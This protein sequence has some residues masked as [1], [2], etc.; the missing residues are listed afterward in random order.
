MSVKKNKPLKIIFLSGFNPDKPPSH[1][2]PDNDYFYVSSWAGLI[3]RRYK[4]RFP[5]SDVEIWRAEPDFKGETVRDV[6]GL[7]G[8][9]FP[10]RRPL[11]K[12]VL[13][14]SMYLR[15]RRLQKNYFLIIHYHCIFD[16]FTVLAPF[17]FSK[18]HLVYSHHGSRVPKPGSLQ[19]QLVKLSYRK[20]EAAT[21][22]SKKCRDYLLGLPINPK[23]I[24]LPVGANFDQFKPLNKMIMR[25]KFG[26][27]PQKI[28]AIYVGNFYRLK[29]VDFILDSYL[30][31]GA[32]Y[33]FTVIF[34]GGREN[35]ENDLFDEVASSGCPYYGPQP[36]TEMANFYNMADFYI[37]PTFH[38]DFGG[39]DVSWMEALACNIPVLSPKLN[40][41]EGP[42]DELG[43]TVDS[44]VEFY[45]KL[46][47]MICN[48]KQFDHCRESAIQRLD[49]KTVI[50]DKLHDL[51][52]SIT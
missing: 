34:V 25:K 8:V 14:L 40:E 21:Y 50:M 43:V 52:K 49:G 44:L 26:L 22:L 2:A 30:Q 45:E 13:T 38:P 19:D 17:F 10:Y 39:L 20:I 18:A 7:H 37:H 46:E 47:W 24:F 42:T 16:L 36:W 9:I 51:Y 35:Q 6:F 11:V 15:L 27:D 29:S 5:E 23:T 28:Y 33:N 32:K 3:A 4:A 41:L 48:F 31:F 1:P 12:N